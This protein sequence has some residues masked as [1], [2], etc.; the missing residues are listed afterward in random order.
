MTSPPPNPAERR[1][2]RVATAIFVA[3]ALVPS[4][5]AI[6]LVAILNGSGDDNVPGKA[7]EDAYVGRVAERVD[8]IERDRQA[9]VAAGRD[10]CADAGEHAAAG[11]RRILVDHGLGDY[12]FQWEFISAAAADHLC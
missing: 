6:V 9:L 5:V 3:A 10:M 1:G 8:V 4:V 7:A 2:Q 11:T 12:A